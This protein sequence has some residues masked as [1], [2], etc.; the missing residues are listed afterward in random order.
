MPDYVADNLMK[1]GATSTFQKPVDLDDYVE[2]LKDITL[3][4]AITME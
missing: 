3:I 1:I 2:I 4:K